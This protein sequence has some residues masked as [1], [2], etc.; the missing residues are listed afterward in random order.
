MA[1]VKDE[2]GF[3]PPFISFALNV[4]FSLHSSEVNFPAGETAALT[5]PQTAIGRTFGYCDPSVFLPTVAK[6]ISA[7]P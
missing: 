6:F 4:Y 5:W 2:S 7:W 1:R 3:L